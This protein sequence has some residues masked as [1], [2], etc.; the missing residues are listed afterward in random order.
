MTG[1]ASMD[2]LKA[3]QLDSNQV[4]RRAF[5]A[6]FIPNGLPKLILIDQGSENK[7]HLIDMCTTIGINYHVVSPDQHNGILCERFH[8]YLNKV[9]KINTADTQS[10]TQWVQGALFAVYAWNAAPIDGTNIMRSFAAKARVFP[11]PIEIKQDHVNRIPPMEGEAAIQHVET[12][13]PIWARQSM[14]LQILQ[15]QRRERHRELR[16]QGVIPR[17]FNVGDIVLIQK[18][19]QTQTI[20]EQTHPAKQ[21]IAKFKG[22]YKVIEKVSDNS[23]MVQKMPSIQGKGKPGKPRKEASVN[24]TPIPS[25]LVLHKRLQEQ[26]TRLA[27]LEHQL[28]NNPLEQAL[29]LHKFGRYIQAPDQTKFVFDKVE[30]LWNQPID[31]DDSSEEDSDIEDNKQ[32]FDDSKEL[33]PPVIHRIDPTDSTQSQDSKRP[34]QPDSQSKQCKRLRTEEPPSNSPLTPSRI[35]L[36]LTQLYATTNTSKDKLF[37]IREKLKWY[38][39]KVDWNKTKE[40]VAKDKG[41]YHVRWFIKNQSDSCNLPTR[42]CRFWPIIQ[43]F[44]PDGTFGEVRMVRPVKWPSFKNTPQGIQYGWY[45]R[46]VDLFRQRLVGPFNFSTIN[47]VPDRISDDIWTSLQ[48]QAQLK[49]IDT[50]DIN[51]I[52][53]LTPYKCYSQAP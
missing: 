4:A 44:K 46:E 53:P 49:G 7:G 12:I 37:F 21:Q 17:K 20:N 2:F 45:Q 28:V 25:T 41:I 23:Y 3:E 33:T 35:N 13:S 14:L 10:F 50:S 9:Q 29:G 15:E 38:L 27:E 30:D 43:K 31:S 36:T 5:A 24:M 42:S 47:G 39:V 22:P 48:E 40:H 1:F 8:R 19:V 11:F 32:G 18:T 26:D 52:S 51:M 6:F 34:A 16:N